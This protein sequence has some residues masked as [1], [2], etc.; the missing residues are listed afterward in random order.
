VNATR[1]MII[2]NGRSLGLFVLGATA[3]VFSMFLLTR[4]QISVNERQ[5]MIEQLESVL[6]SVHYDNDI[7]AQAHT[8]NAAQATGVNTPMPYYIA[9]SR[10]APVALVFTVIAPDG[11]AGPIKLLIGLRPTGEILSVRAIAHQE[12]PGLGDAIEIKKS[13]W[14]SQFDR[15]SLHKTALA[16]WKVKKDTG[17]FDQLTG[18]TITPR[19]VVKAIRNLLIYFQANQTQLL[20]PHVTSQEPLHATLSENLK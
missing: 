10:H 8:L 2:G 3:L 9:T 15:Q 13:N 17:H 19:A 5:V 18:A 4:D 11:Y 1:N 20:H 16:E 14:I 6:L 12:T 7:L